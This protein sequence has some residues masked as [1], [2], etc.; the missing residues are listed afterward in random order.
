MFEIRIIDFEVKLPNGKQ[1]K[2]HDRNLN[3]LLVIGANKRSITLSKYQIIIDLHNGSDVFTVRIIL[4]STS[5]FGNIR[6]RNRQQF[7][8]AW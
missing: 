5:S 3:I 8:K 2:N 6:Q 4:A 1:F 7:I